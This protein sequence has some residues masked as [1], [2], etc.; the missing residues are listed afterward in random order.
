MKKTY[1]L[2]G[3][4]TLLITTGCASKNPQNISFSDLTKE[5]KSNNMTKK[6]EP[7]KLKVTPLV[8]SRTNDA[9]VVM[10]TGVVLKIYVA[11]YKVSTTLIAGHDMYTYVTKPGFIV[12]SDLPKS[13]NKGSISPAQKLPFVFDA[14][15][16]DATDEI[17]NNEIK[18]YIN[19][20][21]EIKSGKKEV[22]KK[23][24]TKNLK[25]DSTIL[26]YINSKKGNP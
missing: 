17:T 11:P 25:N 8:G 20:Q 13:F 22:I 23:V 6:I 15:N 3:T 7:Y 26:N 19:K 9:K 24:E 14:S 12:G 16:I 18:E 10:D 4:L 2:L 21:H 1:L 5:T